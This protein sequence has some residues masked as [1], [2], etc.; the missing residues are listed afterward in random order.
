VLWNFTR[1]PHA[2]SGVAKIEFTEIADG[3][4]FV[5]LFLFLFC[6]QAGKLPLIKT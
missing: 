3:V 4:S 5:F 2:S 6:W 1:A